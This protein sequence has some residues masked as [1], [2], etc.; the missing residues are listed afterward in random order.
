MNGGGNAPLTLT[1]NCIRKV[2]YTSTAMV[3]DYI[4][5]GPWKC[6]CQPYGSGSCSLLSGTWKMRG[7]IGTDGAGLYQRTE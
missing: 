5:S 4:G 1:G 3:Y 7:T 2:F 6:T